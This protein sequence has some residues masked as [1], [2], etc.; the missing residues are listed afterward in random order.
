[1]SRPHDGKDSHPPMTSKQAQKLYRQKNRQPRMSKEEQRRLERLEQERIRKE[2][3]Q[4]KRL[5]RAQFL[6][7]KKKQ[8]EQAK[9]LERKR[10]GLPLVDPRPSQNVIT[11]FI[12]G[13]VVGQKRDASGSIVNHNNESHTEM[14]LDGAEN[15]EDEMEEYRAR[16]RRR[17][18]ALGNNHQ[19]ND[20]FN[21]TEDNNFRAL[22]M[23]PPSNRGQHSGPAPGG[24]QS[25]SKSRVLL[26]LPEAMEYRVQSS[27]TSQ[28]LKTV[29]SGVS[30]L[31]NVVEGTTQ[32]NTIVPATSHKATT[33]TAQNIYTSLNPQLAAQSVTNQSVRKTANPEQRVQQLSGLECDSVSNIKSTMRCSPSRDNSHPAQQPLN[34]R[35]SMQHPLQPRYTRSGIQKPIQSP[36]YVPSPLR[37]SLE[38][39][40]PTST[41][42]F[43]MTHA[44]EFLLSASQEARELAG[45]DYVPEQPKPA[46]IPALVKQSGFR[47]KPSLVQQLQIHTVSKTAPQ[48]FVPHQQL[49]KPVTLKN[50][51]PKPSSAQTPGPVQNAASVRQPPKPAPVKP[52]AQQPVISRQ[53][54]NRFAATRIQSNR[55]VSFLAPLPK[56]APA[57]P[58][59]LN[60]KPKLIEETAA[61]VIANISF[62]D[63]MSTQEER[64]LEGASRKDAKVT[65]LLNELSFFSTQDLFI[66]T[67]EASDL[68]RPAPIKAKSVK[69]LV[70]AEE[71]KLM[72]SDFRD[73]EGSGKLGKH[74]NGVTE[75]KTASFCTQDVTLTSSDLQDIE[76][77]AAAQTSIPKS[78]IE[79]VPANRPSV[80]AV[81]A[82]SD[83]EI[84]DIP[85]PVRPKPC[86]SLEIKPPPFIIRNINQPSAGTPHGSSNLRLLHSFLPPS[87]RT[88]SPKGD[89]AAAIKKPVRCPLE[90]IEDPESDKENG[91]LDKNDN[92]EGAKDKEKK[93]DSTTP[94]PRR[95]KRRFF[96]PSGNGIRLLMTISRNKKAKEQEMERRRVQEMRERWAQATASNS[97][98][99]NATNTAGSSCDHNTIAN[100]KNNTSGKL[101][102][103]IIPCSPPKQITAV[104]PVSSRRRASP[105][106]HPQLSSSQSTDYGDPNLDDE[107]FILLGI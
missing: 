65:K 13:P 61:D 58:A 83:S 43:L 55:V 16:K 54:I 64:E 73:I 84:K 21:A 38:P 18:E 44:D 63:I 14:E 71:L 74:A 69:E 104:P 57:A 47:T 3:E 5:N 85:S 4:E 17:L 9:L 46:Q 7:E 1:M 100:S 88:T 77:P 98:N 59:P 26:H 75:P 50:A 97:N 27:I 105:T 11:K 34:A 95:E 2:L 99:T 53:Q 90:D 101:E 72:S 96:T 76:A 29:A 103:Q 62:Q 92:K 106:V 35:S 37:K 12:R 70:A 79:V 33:T 41:Q 28:E 20:A 49:Q 30:T 19:G 56:P 23:L 81:A 80:Q 52:M 15:Q 89:R 24:L 36:S 68:E 67:Q 32:S 8:Q 45:G 39:Q 102:A 66:S 107:D 48:Q 6:R 87:H 10:Q 60:S 93:A 40:T 22:R 51:A 86:R 91:V 42:L 78:A 82:D 31:Q 25:Q 94:P